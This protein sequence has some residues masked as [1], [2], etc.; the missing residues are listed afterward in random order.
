V[1]QIKVENVPGASTQQTAEYIPLVE[2][3]LSQIPE[4]DQY[5]ITV[6]GNNLNATIE[7]IDLDERAKK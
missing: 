4:I 7:L 5:S 2:Q 3:E 6:N 1:F